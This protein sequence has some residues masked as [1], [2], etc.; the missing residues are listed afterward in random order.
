MTPIF[1]RGTD[2]AIIIYDCTKKETF[3]RAEKWFK[4]LKEYSETNPS[5]ILVGN[6]IDLPNKAVSTEEVKEIADKYDV[7]FFEVSA[8]TGEGIDNI[9]DNITNEIYNSKIEEKENLEVNKENNGEMDENK[10]KRKLVI[11]G[12]ERYEKRNDDSDSAGCVC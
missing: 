2:G 1:Y 8:L 6:K 12:S 5:I 10:R 3:Q 9:F 7:N 4:E 11:S